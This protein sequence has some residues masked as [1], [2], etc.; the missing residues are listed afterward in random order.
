M[1]R[2]P[3][4]TVGSLQRSL[5]LTFDGISQ[6]V[7]AGLLMREKRHLLHNISGDFRAGELTAVMGLSGAGKSTLMDILAGF[8][9]PQSGSVSVNNRPRELAAFRRSSAYIMQDHYLEPLLTVEE[10][11]RVAADLKL[12]S[13]DGSKSERIEQILVALGLANSK[14]TRTANLSGGQRKRL[15]IALEL[16]NNPPF[17]L[18]DE[19]TS[20]LDSVA[21]KQCINLLKALAREGPRTVVITIHQPS[22]TLLDMIDHLHVLVDGSCIYTGGTRNLIPYLSD[23]GLQ[24]PTHYNPADFLMEICN[25]DYGD[26]NKILSQSIENGKNN[27]WRSPSETK[28]H[29]SFGDELNM[30]LPEID[31]SET[32]GSKSRYYATG[33][34]RQ[35][36]V[37]FRRNFIKLSR[38]RILTFTRLTIHCLIAIFKGS[39][40][41]NIG[42]DADEARNNS[43]LLFMSLMFVMFSAFSATL[44]TFPLMLPVIIREHF[45]RW[46]KLRSFY[47]ANKFADL[48]IQ[49]TAVLLYTIILYLMTGQIAEGRRF[50]LLLL[51]YIAVSLVAQLIGL[52]CGIVLSIKY[53]VIFGPFF[54]M[55]FVLFSGFLVH[56]TDAPWYLQWIFHCSFLKYGFQGAMASMYGFGRSQM[57]CNEI[58]CHYTYPKKVLMDFGMK[59]GEYWMPMIVLAILYVILDFIAYACLRLKLKKIL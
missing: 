57:P 7:K 36:L 43:G 17:M 47:F 29:W 42:T 9:S 23:H 22:A 26:Y 34:C 11:M 24:C 31:T 44:I 28:I 54:I 20:G 35:L 32:S 52:I 10:S 38:D 40:F 6:T 19:P 25:G 16:V 1:K 2:S 5:N 51:C 45:N 48:P 18:F 53:G 4:E 46:Y 49:I 8:T 12:Q 55:P 39:V 27:A 37:L 3:E 33:F 30:E 41:Y 13:S 15:A 50:L 58:Y 14:E 21:S 59:S 56:L